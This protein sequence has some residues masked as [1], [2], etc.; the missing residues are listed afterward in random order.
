MKIKKIS[1]KRIQKISMSAGILF[2]F[3]A[4]GISGIYAEEQPDLHTTITGADT[5]TG[6]IMT[7]LGGAAYKEGQSVALFIG[8]IISVILGLLGVVMVGLIIYAGFLWMTAEGDKEK[9]HQG[10]EHLKNAIIGA[11][12]IMSAWTI[13]A[14]V[15]DALGNAASK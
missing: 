2:L 1:M 14:F 7:A 9:I 3:F 10:K 15:I 6:K 13:T 11:I 8:N 12:L 4:F 5:E